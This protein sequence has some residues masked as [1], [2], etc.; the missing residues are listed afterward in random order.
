MLTDNQAIYWVKDPHCLPCIKYEPIILI[1]VKNLGYVCSTWIGSRFKIFDQ[2]EKNCNGQ[3]VQLIFARAQITP[4]I[5]RQCSVPHSRGWL[6]SLLSKIRLIQKIIACLPV[7][8]ISQ[9]VC[10][11]QAFPAFCA[12]EARTLPQREAPHGEAPALVANIALS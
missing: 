10:Q 2:A 8:Q 9:S 3:T 4:M 7:G 6:I 1:R 11:W 5:K 12:G